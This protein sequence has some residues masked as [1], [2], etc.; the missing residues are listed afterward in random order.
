MN[1]CY[2]LLSQTLTKNHTRQFHGK[3]KCSAP[4]LDWFPLLYFFYIYLNTTGNQ[5][6]PIFGHTVLCYFIC[7]F[8]C[9]T[10][11]YFYVMFTDGKF[12]YIIY[13]LYNYSLHV[14]HTG[15]NYTNK[16]NKTSGQLSNNF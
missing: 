9:L 10:F 4:I 5:S 6:T 1:T 11:S 8:S 3:F 7:R 14:I 15:M 2:Q 12:K 13:T 16:L